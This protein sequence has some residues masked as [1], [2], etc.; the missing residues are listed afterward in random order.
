MPGIFFSWGRHVS[1]LVNNM[2]GELSICLVIKQSLVRYLLS[3]ENCSASMFYSEDL[4]V[5]LKE[6]LILL[7]IPTGLAGNVSRV[8]IPQSF[9]IWIKGG[10]Y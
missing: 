5:I 7:S 1:I 3:F 6:G 2:P 4:G 10:C 8:D 9:Q